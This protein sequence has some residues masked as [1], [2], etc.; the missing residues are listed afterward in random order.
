VKKEVFDVATDVPFSVPNKVDMS[1]DLPAKSFSFNPRVA[2]AIVL[3]AMATAGILA[4]KVR[5]NR[6]EKE[7]LTQQE[8]D[9]LASTVNDAEWETEINAPAPKETAKK[10]TPNDVP[11]K[12]V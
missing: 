1:V 6:Q 2:T 9:I 5:K 10:S 12:K 3:G 8:K 4:W 11:S 7:A